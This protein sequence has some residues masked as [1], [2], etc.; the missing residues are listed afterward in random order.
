[1]AFRAPRSSGESNRPFAISS[2][3]HVT[4]SGYDEVRPSVSPA[5]TT[6]LEEENFGY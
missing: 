3:A 5:T 4:L 1:V 2:G 6:A